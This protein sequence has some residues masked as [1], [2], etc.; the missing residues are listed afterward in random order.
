MV[1]TYSVPLKKLVEEFDLQPVFLS[2]DYDKVRVAVDDV[3][4]PSPYF[5]L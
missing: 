1:T 4:E 3:N 5:P 2:S